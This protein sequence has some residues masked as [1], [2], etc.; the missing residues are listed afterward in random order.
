MS[1]FSCNNELTYPLLFVETSLRTKSLS[2]Q[3]LFSLAWKAWKH[4]KFFIGVFLYPLFAIP[5]A[6]KIKL[7]PYLDLFPGIWITTRLPPYI[8]MLSLGLTTLKN[9]KYKWHNILQNFT[10]TGKNYRR[11]NNRPGVALRLVFT[12][13]RVVVEVVR[14]LMTKWK[15]KSRS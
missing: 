12:S 9:C 15:S 10:R 3:G 6:Y 8:K 13:D 1:F 4:C 7:L 5:S 14:A 11:T 2:Y